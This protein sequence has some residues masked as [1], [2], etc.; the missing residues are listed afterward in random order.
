MNPFGFHIC[1]DGAPPTQTHQSRIRAFRI[2]AHCRIVKVK[3]DKRTAQFQRELSEKVR[4][5]M[6]D[7][8]NAFPHNGPMVVRI[9]YY[10][11]APKGKKGESYKTT[12]PDAD[13]MVKTVLDAL[14]E[15][16]I[17]TDDSRVCCLTVQKLMSHL[18]RTE[19]SIVPIL[20]Q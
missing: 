20:P 8:P 5:K 15:T 4:D 14:T 7:T 9:S 11:P 19:I 16:G 1:V 10:F 12:R 17:W 3:P 18:P 2:G 13:N 6:K